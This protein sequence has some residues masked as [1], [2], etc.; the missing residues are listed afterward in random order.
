MGFK[1]ENKKM[2]R[3]HIPSERTNNMEGFTTS[4]PGRRYKQYAR[5]KID[6]KRRLTDV[7]SGVNSTKIL[8]REK[9]PVKSSKGTPDTASIDMYSKMNGISWT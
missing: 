4:I 2:S 5:E 9:N 8:D 3:S 7:Y 1:I 6:T